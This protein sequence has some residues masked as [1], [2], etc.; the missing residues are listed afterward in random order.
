MSVVVSKRKT[1]QLV[2]FTKLRQLCA[3]TKTIVENETYFPVQNYQ[4]KGKKV[5]Q[6]NV[7]PVLAKRIYNSVL[8]VNNYAN[9]ANKVFVKCQV[10]YELRRKYQAEA[11]SEISAL[12]QDMEK[13]MVECNIPGRVMNYWVGLVVEVQELLRNWRNSEYKTAKLG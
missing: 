4:V 5:V 3:Y 13:A 6:N 12:L 10:D 8:S 11:I 1:G 2:V 9:R 7:K